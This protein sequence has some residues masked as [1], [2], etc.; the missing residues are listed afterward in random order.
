M[1]KNHGNAGSGRWH[2]LRR[3]ARE[4]WTQYFGKDSVTNRIKAVERLQRWQELVACAIPDSGADICVM[5][6]DAWTTGEALVPNT[7]KKLIPYG[8][9]GNWC[10]VKRGFTCYLSPEG[11]PLAILRIN[12]G[13]HVPNNAESLLSLSHLEAFGVHVRRQDSL[14][15]LSKPEWPVAIHCP[16]RGMPPSSSV[17][18]GSLSASSLVCA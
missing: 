15:Q 1:E 7:S 5:A 8:G 12:Y 17:S 4:F 14:L 3:I 2:V 6:G 9:E 18:S 13:V 16:P 11:E 10:E